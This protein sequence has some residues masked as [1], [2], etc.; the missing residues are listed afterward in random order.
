MS[1]YERGVQVPSVDAGTVRRGQKGG[2]LSGIV[3]LFY[4]QL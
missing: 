1:F 4:I 3:H 2:N